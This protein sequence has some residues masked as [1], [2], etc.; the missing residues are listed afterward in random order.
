MYVQT[1]KGTNH[2]LLLSA[3]DCLHMYYANHH[4]FS[5]HLPIM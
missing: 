3:Y 5:R 1:G 2:F 4:L